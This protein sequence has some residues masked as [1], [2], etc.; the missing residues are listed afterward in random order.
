M[1]TRAPNPLRWPRLTLAAVFLAAALAGCG[2]KENC[3]GGWCGDDPPPDPP[4]F[5]PRTSPANLLHN[6]QRAYERRNVAEYESLLAKDF[7]FVLSAEDQ[8]YP[9]MPDSWERGPEVQIHTHMFD[10]GLVQ[11]LTLTFVPADSVWNPADGMYTVLMSN[12]NL[13]LLGATPAHP[14]DVKE[15]RMANGWE[16]FWFRKNGWTVPG[17]ADSV[18]TIVKWQDSPTG[19][20][21]ARGSALGVEVTWGAIKALFE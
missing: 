20:L 15:Y 5:L 16:K 1:S 3:W 7:T 18:W 12:V 21:T 4:A 6:L 13:Y 10:A 8:Q 9:G 2:D 19:G 11:T 14:G 17:K